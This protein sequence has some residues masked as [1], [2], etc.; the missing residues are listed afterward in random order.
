MRPA[1]LTTLLGLLLAGSAGAAGDGILGS[2]HNLSV[3]GPGQI[4]ATSESQVCVFCHVG[5]GDDVLGQNRPTADAPGYIAYASTTLKARPSLAPT[6]STRICL[7]C[8]DGTIALGQTLSSGDIQLHGTGAGGRL[9]PGRSNLGTDLRRTHPVSLTPAFSPT[10]RP[11]ESAKVK[12]DRNGQLQCTSCHDPHQESPDGVQGKFLVAS[13]RYSALCTSC[14]TPAYWLTNPSAH[15]A[16]NALYDEHRGAQTPFATVAENGCESCHSS[17]GADERGRLLRKA[18]SDRDDE[19]CLSCHDGR[20]ARADIEADVRKPYAHADPDREFRAHDAAEG[21]R[22][23]QL[24]LPE[25]NPGAPRHVACVDCHNPHATYRNPAVA[26]NAAGALSG[27]WGIDAAGQRVEPVKYEYEVC[28][29]C[30]GDSANQP[31]ARGQNAPGAPV[32]AV[33]EPNLRRAFGSDAVSFHPVMAPGRNPDVPSL[34]RPLSAGSIIYCG[35]CH[36]SDSGP[37][38]GGTGPAGPH[39]SVYPF[40]LER[41]LSTASGAVESPET[42]ALCYKC[43]DREVLLS[44]RSAFR[45]HRRHV[46]DSGA[47]CTACHDSHG[48]AATAGNDS[49]NAHLINFDISIVRPGPGGIR[50]YQSNGPRSGACTVACHGASHQDTRY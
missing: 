44:D 34:I 13:N 35:D 17:H 32:R 1:P 6:G 37:G 3:S 48:V 10:L 46:V 36:A 30:H 45:A 9:P 23:A 42:Y 41:R 4:R 8:H 19:L 31:R 39:G 15:Q 22:Q 25:T 43:H 11:P 16:S 38:A 27:V 49:G 47:P 20:V 12:L 40:L 18:K 50:R 7:S 5:H 28:L 21:P 33:P 26:P 29:K 14:H 24:S 2:K